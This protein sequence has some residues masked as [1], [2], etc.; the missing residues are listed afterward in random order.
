VFVGGNGIVVKLDDRLVV[1][2]RGGKTQA[3]A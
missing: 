1:D 3:D 2:R